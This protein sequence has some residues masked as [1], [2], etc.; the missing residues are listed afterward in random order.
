VKVLKT[1]FALVLVVSFVAVG[2]W[3]YPR[4]AARFTWVVIASVH[5]SPGMRI[6]EGMAILRLWPVANVP[7]GAIHSLADVIG[8]YAVE[9]EVQRRRSYSL[10]LDGQTPRPRTPR[11]G[12]LFSS[13][14]VTRE[15]AA[16]FHVGDTVDVTVTFFDTQNNQLVNERKVI[17]SPDGVIARILHTAECPILRRHGFAEIFIEIEVEEAFRL[18]PIVS[19]QFL[20]ALL[21]RRDSSR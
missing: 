21:T 8:K 7:E 2:V 4:V 13:Y 5:L 11:P 1:I 3:G 16:K 15:N 19:G 14:A 18:A 20:P 9:Q 17:V 10:R 12:Y 6:E